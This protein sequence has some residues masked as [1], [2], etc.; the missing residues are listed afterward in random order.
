MKRAFGAL[1]QAWGP[2]AAMWP[3]DLA[4]A[5]QAATA[6]GDAAQ[7]AVLDAEA[8]LAEVKGAK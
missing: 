2:G 8:R 6:E 3:A 1:E 4:K 7:K 5:V